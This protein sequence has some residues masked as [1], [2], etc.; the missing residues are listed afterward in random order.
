M[1]YETHNL[2]NAKKFQGQLLEYI[3]D[4]PFDGDCKKKTT[5]ILKVGAIFAIK[6]KPDHSDLS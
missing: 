1:Y 4:S 3:V 5:S 6:I 2:Q